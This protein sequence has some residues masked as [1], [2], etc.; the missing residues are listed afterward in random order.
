[1]KEAYTTTATMLLGDDGILRITMKEGAELKLED[2]KNHYLV[3]ARLLGE[4]KGLVLLDGRARYTLTSEARAYIR[5]MNAQT[6]IATAILVGSNTSRRIANFI[7]SLSASPVPTR[8]FTD[9]EEAI[10][11]LNSFRAV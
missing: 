9:M 3:T 8:A 4:A 10:R 1:M 11:W 7:S 5:Q 2:A 6:R